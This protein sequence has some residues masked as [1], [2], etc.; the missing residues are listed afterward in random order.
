[1]RDDVAAKL[2]AFDFRRAFHLAGEV[3]GD[4]LA[5][6]RSVQAFQDQI[7]RFGPAQVAEHHFAESTTEPGFTTS[8]FTYFGA[9]PCV[10]RKSRGR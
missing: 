10:A 4:A 2:A 5:A 8:L 9:V 1:V 3:V 6:D 7:G